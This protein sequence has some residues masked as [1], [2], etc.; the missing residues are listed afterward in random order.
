MYVACLVQFVCC[1][2]RPVFFVCAA[3]VVLSLGSVSFDCGG[4]LCVLSEVVF[5]VW[6]G[7]A[8]VVGIRGFVVWF[9][10]DLQCR[11]VF[12][13]S[14]AWVLEYLLNVRCVCVWCGA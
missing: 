7:S 4:C 13:I 1:A 3:Y 6:V 8:V 12:V 5:G 11:F 9:V 2:R 10:C 14:K